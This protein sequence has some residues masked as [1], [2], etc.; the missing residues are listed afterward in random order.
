[1]VCLCKTSC[2]HRYAGY[3]HR[4]SVLGQI[5][6]APGSELW[7]DPWERSWQRPTHCPTSQWIQPSWAEEKQCRWHSIWS[8]SPYLSHSWL[9]FPLENR[10]FWVLSCVL[11]W[12]IGILRLVLLPSS[13]SGSFFDMLLGQT[14]VTLFC[15]ILGLFRKMFYA[16]ILEVLMI[17]RVGQI[18]FCFEEIFSTELM[19][20]IF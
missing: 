1:M 16:A 18:F 12:S 10:S 4:R 6:W 2:S 3:Q 5:P 7:L 14:T 19:H 13:H 9:T 15:C 20:C 11:S 8:H 17:L